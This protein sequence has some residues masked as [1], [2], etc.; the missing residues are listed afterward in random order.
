MV[1]VI[2]IVMLPTEN[3]YLTSRID[4]QE[5]AISFHQNRLTKVA[6]SRKYV[7]SMQFPLDLCVI[8]FLIIMLIFNLLVCFCRFVKMGSDVFFFGSKSWD[9][10]LKQ[11]SKQCLSHWYLSNLL[12]HFL[13]VFLRNHKNQVPYSTRILLSPKL[14]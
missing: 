12:L 8:M 3:I 11:K 10:Q 7:Q 4:S 6:S 14:S 13:T 1:A 2:V 9:I 5:M